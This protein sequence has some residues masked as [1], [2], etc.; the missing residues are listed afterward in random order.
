MRPADQVVREFCAAVSARDA[1]ALGS[2]FHPDAVFHDIS[3]HP[4]RGRDAVLAGLASIFGRFE[5]ITFEIKYLATAGEVVLTERIDWL[6]TTGHTAP[7]PVMGAFEVHDGLIHQW[8]DY[9]DRASA[10]A[11]IRDSAA[12]AR[13]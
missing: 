12:T 2:F 4:Q 11:L 13:I 8:R 5:N 1:S 7:I 9:F 3:E 6:G 10:T